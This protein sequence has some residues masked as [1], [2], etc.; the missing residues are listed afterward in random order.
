[1][2]VQATAHRGHYRDVTGKSPSEHSAAVEPARLARAAQVC[3]SLSAG[4]FCRVEGRT[5]TGTA[6]SR[7]Q[8]GATAASP[9]K[10]SKR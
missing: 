8:P 3:W 2:L 6:A 9:A 7:S 10:T 4:G 5:W 1:M